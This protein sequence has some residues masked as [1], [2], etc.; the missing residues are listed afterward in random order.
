MLSYDIVC[1]ILGLAISVEH[2]LVTGRPANGRT[3]TRY[4][5]IPRYHSIARLKNL[6]TIASAIPEISLGPQNWS[7]HPDHAPF[8]GDLSSICWD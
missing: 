1:V 6:T 2:R 8:K 7:Q 3:G 4:R 5:S